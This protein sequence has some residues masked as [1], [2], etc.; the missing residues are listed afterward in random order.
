[1]VD[2][3]QNRKS[4]IFCTR[5]ILFLYLDINIKLHDLLYFYT[6]PCVYLRLL[7]LLGTFS[8]FKKDFALFLIF[9]KLTTQQSSSFIFV[10]YLSS[11]FKSK[12][13]FQDFIFS[14]KSIEKGYSITYLYCSFNRLIGKFLYTNYNFIKDVLNAFKNFPWLSFKEKLA[15][16]NWLMSV[17]KP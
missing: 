16:L 1:M 17:F 15:S 8:I 6:V 2:T 11:L 9:K 4:F 10:Q 7:D 14:F 3:H 5:S 12:I 13:F